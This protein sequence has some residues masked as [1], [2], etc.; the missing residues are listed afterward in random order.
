MAENKERSE[1]DLLEEAYKDD[2]VEGEFELK[3]GIKVFMRRSD[4]FEMAEKQEEIKRDLVEKYKIQYG[5]KPVDEAMWKNTEKVL[6][7][8]KEKNDAVEIKKPASYAEQLA[9][10][11]INISYLKVI[12]P[13]FLRS[14][15]TGLRLCQNEEQRGRLG[16]IIISTPGIQDMISV[17]TK[18]ITEKSDQI[19]EAGKNSSTQED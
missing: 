16:D 4:V 19:K 2:I 15:K 12:F 18:Q 6:K 7:E 17:I 1:L 11:H 5:D 8:A 10:S 14:R 9:Q 13:T 3:G